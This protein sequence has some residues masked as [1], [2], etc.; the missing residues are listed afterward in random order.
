MIDFKCSH[1]SNKSCS[2]EVQKYVETLSSI[3]FSPMDLFN[4][5]HEMEFSLPIGLL[6]CF[7]FHPL[8]FMLSYLVENSRV[9][10]ILSFWLVSKKP[11]LD[12]NF[13]VFWMI[14][15]LLPWKKYVLIGVFAFISGYHLARWAFCSFF[16]GNEGNFVELLYL[17]ELSACF[18]SKHRIQ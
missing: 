5:I 3:T 11:S 7:F 2:S 4:Y 1:V 18:I 8:L 16:L 9:Y 6:F 17:Q 14:V 12:F 15:F 10:T 13:K